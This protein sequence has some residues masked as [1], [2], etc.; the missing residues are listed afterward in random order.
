MISV[1]SLFC[2]P[3]N[4]NSSM[5]EIPVTRSGMTFGTYVIVMARLWSF[6]LRYASPSEL[7][8]PK[9]VDATAAMDATLRV[10]RRDSRMPLPSEP[11]NRLL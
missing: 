9:A 4:E 11:L 10:S 2:T 3:R 1:N 8:T 5:N 7:R 6:L